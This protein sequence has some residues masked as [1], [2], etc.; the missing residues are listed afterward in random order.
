MEIADIEGEDYNLKDMISE[1]LKQYLE[2]SI[3]ELIDYPPRIILSKLYYDSEWRNAV[4]KAAKIYITKT[5]NIS[6]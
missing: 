2:K 4:I 3:K 5:Y 1:S 6:K